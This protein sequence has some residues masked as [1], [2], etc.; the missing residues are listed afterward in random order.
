MDMLITDGQLNVQG[1]EVKT[2]DEFIAEATS[3]EGLDLQGDMYID[4]AA[5]PD[6]D[7]YDMLVSSFVDAGID[8][9]FIELADGVPD[10]YSGELHPSPISNVN[11]GI[12]VDEHALNEINAALSMLDAEPEVDENGL[13]IGKIITFGSAKGGAGKTFTSIIT[14]VYYAKDHPNERVCLLDLDVEEPQVGA[15]IRMLK[16][17]IRSFYSE[18]E[19]GNTGFEYM[20]KCKAK[21]SHMPPNLDFYLTPRDSHAVVDPDFWET[22]MYNLFTNYDMTILDTG[23]T[24]MDT[25]AIVSAYK[26]ADKINL[27]TQASLTSTLAVEDQIKRLTGEKPNDVYSAEDDLMSKINLIITNSYDDTICNTIVDAMADKAN[28]IAKFGNLSQKINEIQI[29]GV[30]DMFDNNPAF[31]QGMRDIYS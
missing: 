4:V 5:I 2:Y 17:T 29:L 18:Y 19:V 24:Y 6:E 7:N 22:C 15:A 16:P 30:W 11:D 21:N 14:A 13:S 31:R 23:T 26:V 28:I 9:Q 3:D 10:W 25:P 12:N 1:Y 8:I 27:V 20:E